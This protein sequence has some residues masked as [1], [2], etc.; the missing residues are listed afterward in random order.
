VIRRDVAE[1]LDVVPDSLLLLLHLGEGRRD[2]FGVVLDLGV[3]ANFGLVD[4]VA[5]VGTFDAT[6]EAECDEEADGDSEEMNEEVADA[7]DRGVRGMDF[8]HRGAS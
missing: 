1:D 2:G 6:F 4:E 8:D 5:V 3:E 7:M